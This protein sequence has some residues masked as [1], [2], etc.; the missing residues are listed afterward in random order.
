MERYFTLIGDKMPNTEQV[1]LPSWESRRDIYCRYKEDM[2][3]QEMGSDTIS[4]D[5][6]LK[7]GEKIFPMLL[8][9]R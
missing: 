1:H 4:L 6:F 2:S 9:Q 5:M 7:Y 3:S 8:S